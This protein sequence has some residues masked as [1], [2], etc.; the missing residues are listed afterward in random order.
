MKLR[1]DFDA[2]VKNKLGKGCT[3]ADLV[4][5]DIESPTYDL[6]ADDVSGE[7]C[8]AVDQEEEVTPKG[9]MNTSMRV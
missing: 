6:Y 4:A 7:Q 9:E 5:E 3:A 8:H 1:L 2:Q